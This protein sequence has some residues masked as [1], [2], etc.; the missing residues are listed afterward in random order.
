MWMLCEMV[1]NCCAF[2]IFFSIYTVVVSFI[3]QRLIRGQRKSSHYYMLELKFSAAY[4]HVSR[5]YD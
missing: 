2:F 1:I 4:Y 5:F 3:L